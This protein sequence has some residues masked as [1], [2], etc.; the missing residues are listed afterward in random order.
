MFGIHLNC[1][2]EYSCLLLSVYLPCDNNTNTVIVEYIDYI[3][4]L[5]IL[6]I[7]ARLFVAEILTF[8]SKDQAVK[9]HVLKVVSP[10]IIYLYSG[11]IMY[12]RNI[13]RIIMFLYNRFSCIDHIIITKKIYILIPF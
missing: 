4:Q 12:Q 7:V 3:E 1:S 13:I 9:L 2:S 8:L 6:S 10:G 11:I 5:L